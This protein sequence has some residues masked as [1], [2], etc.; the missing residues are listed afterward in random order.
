MSPNADME[1]RIDDETYVFV[2]V[3]FSEPEATANGGGIGV[4]GLSHTLRVT[5]RSQVVMWSMIPLRT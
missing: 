2:L 4:V 5:P 3:E 1:A